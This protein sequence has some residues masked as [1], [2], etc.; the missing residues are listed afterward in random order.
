MDS[1][2]YAYEK[3]PSHPD[4]EL[5]A[6]TRSFSKKRTHGTT[7]FHGQCKLAGHSI[8]LKSYSSGDLEALVNTVNEEDLEVTSRAPVPILRYYRATVSVISQRMPEIRVNSEGSYAISADFVLASVL[9]TV[10]LCFIGPVFVPVAVAVCVVSETEQRR[11]HDWVVQ[12]LLIGLAMYLLWTMGQAVHKKETLREFRNIQYS[13]L[14]LCGPFLCY[15]IISLSFMADVCQRCIELGAGQMILDEMHEIREQQDFVFKT[16]TETESSAEPVSQDDLNSQLQELAFYMDRHVCGLNHIRC[17]LL[18]QYPRKLTSEFMKAMM[19]MLVVPDDDPCSRTAVAVPEPLH[20]VLSAFDSARALL[21][22]RL[23]E[24][25]PERIP[26]QWLAVFMICALVPAMLP[27]LHRW[28]NGNHDIFSSKH[29]GVWRCQRAYMFMMFFASWHLIISCANLIDSLSKL[30]LATLA[31][32]YMSAPRKRR[33]VLADTYKHN[34]DHLVLI[35]SESPGDLSL[36]DE[37]RSDPVPLKDVEDHEEKMLSRTISQ[38]YGHLRYVVSGSSWR[39]MQLEYVSH[40]ASDRADRIS[41]PDMESAEAPDDELNS[42]S[43]LAARKFSLLQLLM[44]ADCVV[45]E[46]KSQII[47]MLLSLILV[48]CGLILVFS[49]FFHSQRG[50][51]LFFCCVMF[52]VILIVIVTIMN[53][54]VVLDNH[55]FEDTVKILQCWRMRLER[56]RFSATLHIHTSAERTALDGFLSSLPAVISCACLFPVVGIT[57]SGVLQLE[58]ACVVQL[59]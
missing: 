38:G 30:Q 41:A 10:L 11:W 29:D 19:R 58:I 24:A 7:L 25:A 18:Q 46:M 14:E 3:V 50:V 33:A 1:R 42:F 6:H 32:L 20:F 13:M 9:L 53:Q 47:L 39:V 51:M 31:K 57:S 34:F 36:E 48:S 15:L 52:P 27:T 49:V 26:P 54:L 40:L 37:A 16:N 22:Q 28:L 45:L 56:L 59:A 35:P 43:F 4:P 5:P 2:G 12:P 44:R 8:R 17:R 21:Q 55:L 23:R